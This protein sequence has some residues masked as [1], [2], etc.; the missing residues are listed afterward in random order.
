MG[1][2]SGGGIEEQGRDGGVLERLLEEHVEERVKCVFL[3]EWYK[4]FRS[5]SDGF[6]PGESNTKN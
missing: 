6:K 3:S 5:M 2:D 4:K 1:G